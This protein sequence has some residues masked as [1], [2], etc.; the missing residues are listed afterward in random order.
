L[1][2]DALSL[3]HRRAAG[4]FAA[5]R[6]RLR[7]QR[8][9]RWCFVVLRQTARVVIGLELARVCGPEDPVEAAVLGET[10]AAVARGT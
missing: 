6:L 5:W 3:D 1:L 7:T 8:C 9:L 2:S 10:D 4:F